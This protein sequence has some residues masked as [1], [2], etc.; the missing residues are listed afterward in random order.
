MSTAPMSFVPTLAPEELA[1]ANFYGL[2]A[3]LFCAPPDAALLQTLAAADD[4][5]AEDGGVALAWRDLAQAAAAADPEAVRKEYDGAF[6]STAKSPIHL[7][8]TPNSVPY[9]NDKPLFD[10]HH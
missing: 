7:Y 4:L 1:R 8:T 10:L 6:I 9:T 3:R 5:E 2:L